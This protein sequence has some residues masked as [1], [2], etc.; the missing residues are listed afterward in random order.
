MSVIQIVSLLLAGIAAVALAVYLERRASSSRPVW[1]P[2]SAEAADFEAFQGTWWLVSIRRD[3]APGDGRPCKYVFAGDRMLVQPEGK[4]AGE[5]SFWLDASHQPKLFVIIA[6]TGAGK[7]SPTEA[8]YDVK[9]DE[10]RWCHVGGQCP[11]QM[12]PDDSAV[13]T[14]VTLRRA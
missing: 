9:G 2:S 4:Q 5:Y 14:I 8:A 7:V 11:A 6:R 10:L 13:G 3:G 12:L 1:T